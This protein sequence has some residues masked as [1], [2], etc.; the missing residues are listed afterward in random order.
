MVNANN[1]KA[2]IDTKV[3][4]ALGSTATLQ[5]KSSQTVDAWGDATPTYG[6]SASIV[7][8]PWR[9][10]FNKENFEAFGDLEKGDV[11]LA[12]KS[13]QS[14]EVDDR[15]TWNAKIYKVKVVEYYTLKDV[16]L[17]KAVRLSETLA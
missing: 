2:K 10:V 11:D 1:V 6:T 8:V 9:H 17:V 15:L 7:V 14:I 4:T 16:L 3:F 12:V 13:E 5:S